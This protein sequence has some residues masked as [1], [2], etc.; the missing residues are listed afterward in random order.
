MGVIRDSLADNF[1]TLTAMNEIMDFI[2]ISHLYIQ[3]SSLIPECIYFLQTSISNVLDIFGLEPY[4]AT[5]PFPLSNQKIEP[6]VDLIIQL[7]SEIKKLAFQSE[8]SIKS[9]LFRLVD[10]LRDQSLPKLGIKL[11]DRKDFTVW[12]PTDKED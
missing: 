4:H 11:E 9:Q 8:P 5:E 3:S 2:S 7:R 6:F 10:Q 12:K 1:D